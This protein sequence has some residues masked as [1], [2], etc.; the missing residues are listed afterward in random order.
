MLLRL[1]P[2]LR[3]LVSPHPFSLSIPV[4]FSSQ[5]RSQFPQNI[6]FHPPRVPARCYVTNRISLIRALTTLYPNYLLNF[7]SL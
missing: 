5:L 3:T 2:L 7:L 1:G 6:F 4:I